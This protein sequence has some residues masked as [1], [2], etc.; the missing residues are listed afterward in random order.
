MSE[1]VKEPRSKSVLTESLGSLTGLCA[2][3]AWWTIGIVVLSAVFCVYLTTQRLNFKTDRSDLINPEAGFYQ[4]WINYTKDFGQFDDI[5]VVIESNR[6]E[7]LKEAIDDVGSRLAGQPKLFSNVLYRIDPGKLPEKGLQYLPA[8]TLANGLERLESF[9]PILNGNWGLITLDGVVTRLQSQLSRVKN[10]PEMEKQLLHH[11]DLLITSLQNTMQDGDRFTNPWPEILS[12]PDEMEEQGKQSDYMLNETGTMGFVMA[13]AVQDKG[14]FEGPTL[15]IDAVRKLLADAQ[16]KFPDVKFLLTGIS[17]LENDEMRRS[18][19]DSTTASVISFVGVAI[20]LFLGFRGFLHPFLGLFMLAVG[21]AWSFGYT[22]LMIGH[23]NILSVSFAAM[24]MGLGIDFAV[25]ILSRYL[26]L[27]HQGMGLIEAIVATTEGVGVGVVTGAVTTSLAFF[28]ATMTDFLGVAEL[29]VIAGGGILLCALA[30]FTVLPAAIAVADRRTELLELPKPFEARTLRAAILN[31]PWVILTASAVFLGFIGYRSFDWSGPV[32]KPLV[33]YDHNL[34]HL[35]AEGLESV[36][37]QNHIFE[38][39]KHSL[40]YALSIADSP[41]EARELKKKFEQLP[42]VREVQELATR[43]PESLPEAKRL[44]IQGY[45]AQLSQLPAAPPEPQAAM[46]A[47]NGR[48][49]EKL[50]DLLKS[51]RDPE[52]Q[53]IASS[54]DSILN[55]LDEESLQRQMEFLGEFQY[56]M[57]Y[58]LLAQFQAIA[59]AS[60]PE[61]VTADDLPIELRSRFVSPQGKWLLQIFPKDQIW[62]MEPLQRFVH[63]VRTVDADATGTPL[64]NYEAARQIKRSYEICALYALGVILVTLVMDFSTRNQLFWTFFPPAVMALIAGILMVTGQLQYN[65]GLLLAVFTVMTLV[66]SLF[67]GRT[68]VMDTLLAMIPPMVGLGISCGVL[69]ILNIPLNPANLIIL[70][71]ILG[72]G[73]DNGVHIMHDF[74]SKPNEVYCP[75]PSTI[76]AIVMT[77][78]TTMVG[79]GS[80]MI[81]AH[82]GLYSLGAVLTIGVGS[83]MFVSLIML[84]SILCLFSRHRGLSTKG[85]RGEGVVDTEFDRDAAPVSVESSAINRLNQAARVA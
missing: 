13:S 42:T 73:V 38:S 82:R 65:P 70:P 37:A 71:L 78:T 21:M 79:F 11:T 7:A 77:S 43:I 39:S 9:R 41:E 6:S 45:H 22:T 10:D 47:A 85:S 51:R 62:D 67:L 26:E 3:H 53:R 5:I 63:E 18:M 14:S 61:P 54:I 34:L 12:V 69:V 30:A 76:N 29:G 31:Y 44:L 58:A 74:H 8:N 66:L 60:N 83:C 2:R 59:S 36:E 16:Q 75:S 25:H 23:L 17:V 35:Q 33:V 72:I 49:L 57:A 84:P 56:R 1:E 50:Y 80:M 40:L 15:A 46:P 81:S 32:P 27:R 20:L 19:A 52:S 55:A 48:A 24:L 68:A 4:R 28:C 64:Q